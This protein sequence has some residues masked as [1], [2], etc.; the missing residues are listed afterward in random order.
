MFYDEPEPLNYCFLLKFVF[1]LGTAGLIA[2]IM[3]KPRQSRFDYP[4][5]ESFEMSDPTNS[6]LG[7]YMLWLVYY[8]IVDRFIRRTS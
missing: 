2:T 3:L 8:D 1:L 4:R 6:L 5:N 7:T